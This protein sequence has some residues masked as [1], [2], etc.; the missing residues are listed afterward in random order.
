MVKETRREQMKLKIESLKK[1]KHDGHL[2]I[3]VPREMLY[4]MDQIAK[5][6]GLNRTDLVIG[7]IDEFLQDVKSELY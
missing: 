4:R 2:N 7:L 1:P 5:Q 6:H 3:R